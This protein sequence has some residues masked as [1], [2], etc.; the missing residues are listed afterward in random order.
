MDSADEKTPAELLGR[1]GDLLRESSHLSDDLEQARRNELELRYFG[2]VERRLRERRAAER[3][4]A[5]DR[6]RHA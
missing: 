5:P 4:A 6:R 3:R 2:A 1:I